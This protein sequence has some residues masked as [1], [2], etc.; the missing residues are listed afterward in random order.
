MSWN[1][2]YRMLQEGEVIL[3]SDEIQNDDGSWRPATAVGKKAPSP[4]Y[5]SHRIYRRAALD[6]AGFEIREKNDG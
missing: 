6:A 5:T 4:R 1:S 2:N 3:A